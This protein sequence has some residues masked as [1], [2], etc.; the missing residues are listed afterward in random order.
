ML[1]LCVLFLAKKEELGSAGGE[2]DASKTRT[3][4]SAALSQHT[5]KLM[6][7]ILG[8]LPT[9]GRLLESL[10]RM[11]VQEEMA[12]ALALLMRFSKVSNV[13]F[14]PMIRAAEFC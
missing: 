3:A 6:A 11:T 10:G 12:Q 13:S 7:A 9:A 5:G 8:A 1:F 14:P 4:V 2:S